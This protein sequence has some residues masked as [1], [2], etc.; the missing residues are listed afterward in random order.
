MKITRRRVWF[1]LFSLSSAIFLVTVLWPLLVIRTASSV[2]LFY[3]SNNPNSEF[4]FWG[5]RNEMESHGGEHYEI[6]HNLAEVR[7]A[8][9]E[10]LVFHIFAPRRRGY[11]FIRVRSPLGS[12]N[13]LDDNM[14]V[15]YHVSCFLGVGTTMKQKI[16]EISKNENKDRR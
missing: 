12:L 8:L 14:P 11:A 5:T 3:P 10:E 4:S 2:D 1:A 16:Y 6:K 7:S 13:I 9:Q 15:F